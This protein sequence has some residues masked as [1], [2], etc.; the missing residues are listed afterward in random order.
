MEDKQKSIILRQILSCIT[1]PYFQFQIFEIFGNLEP[2]FS[3]ISKKC[4][5]KVISTLEVTLDCRTRTGAKGLA[6]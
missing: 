5:L 4:L 6:P 1:P 2:N 3:I